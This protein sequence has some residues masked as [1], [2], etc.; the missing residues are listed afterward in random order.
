MVGDGDLPAQ[1]AGEGLLQFTQIEGDLV[2][3][4]AL[5]R[6]LRLLLE[7]LHQLLGLT[8]GEAPDTTCLAASRWSSAVGAPK[9]ARAWPAERVP[10]STK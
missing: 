4:A 9:M 6:L 5:P 1:L 10:S 3:G 2:C 8:D 7:E